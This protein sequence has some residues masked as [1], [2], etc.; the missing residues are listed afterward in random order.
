MHD[1]TPLVRGLRGLAPAAEAHLNRRQGA[2]DALDGLEDLLEK[3]VAGQ[4]SGQCSSECSDWVDAIYVRFSICPSTWRIGLIPMASLPGLQD[5]SEADSYTQVGMCA[6]GAGPTAKM[7]TCG[8]CKS[9][10]PR[11][12]AVSSCFPQADINFVSQAME[13]RRRRAQRVS[14]G[15]QLSRRVVEH[16]H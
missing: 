8:S 12:I 13:A 3:V 7:R 11:E 4:S 1:F 5:C 14:R 15:P 10:L 16:A 2:S 6:C 9:S